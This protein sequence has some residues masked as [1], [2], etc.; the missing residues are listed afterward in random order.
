MGEIYSLSNSIGSRKDIRRQ[1][2]KWGKI[3][4]WEKHSNDKPRLRGAIWL[5]LEGCFVTQDDLARRG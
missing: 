3:L 2:T 5:C 1:Q 4:T